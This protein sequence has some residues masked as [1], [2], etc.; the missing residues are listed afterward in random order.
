MTTPTPPHSPHQEFLAHPPPPDAATESLGVLVVLV[1]L[2]TTLSG[3]ST[4][5]WIALEFDGGP[6]ELTLNEVARLLPSAE[7]GSTLGGFAHLQLQYLTWPTVLVAA[8]ASLATAWP[9]PGLAPR[10]GPRRLAVAACVYGVAA[11]ALLAVS[12]DGLGVRE[13]YWSDCRVLAGPWV[14]AIG[15]ALMLLG[16]RISRRSRRPAPAPDAGPTPVERHLAED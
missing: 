11:T 6:A 9:R 5:A 8:L 1:G 15:L 13:G 12:L 10:R 14:T 2:V 3:V 16:V 4:V 7:K